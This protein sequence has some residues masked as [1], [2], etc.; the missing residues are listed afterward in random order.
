MSDWAVAL[1]AAIDADETALLATRRHL[2]AHPDL[3]GA[4][5]RTVEWLTRQLD[6]VAIPYR[7][8]LSGRGILCGPDVDSDLVAFR[9]DIDGL[10]IHDQKDVPY[11][12]TVPGAM[13]AC[14]HD[15]HSAMAL[16]AARAL[17]RCRE[18]LPWPTPWRAIFQPAE[19]TGEGA[20]E[21]VAA[22]AMERVRAIVALHVDPDLE[23]GRV[24][25]RTGV[26]TASCTDIEVTVHGTGGHAARPH[27]TTDPIAAAVEL[28]SQ[29]YRVVPRSVDA[30]EAVVVTFGSIHGGAS[31]NVIPDRVEL[32]GT[33]R[34]QSRATAG[35]VQGRIHAIG[36]SVSQATGATIDIRFERG[37][38]AVI[39]DPEVT[40][41][42]VE[43]V[44]ELVGP[45]QV[46]AIDLPSMGGED[47]GGYLTQG[48]GC[49]LRLG[50]AIA[51][52]PRV[53]LHS[54]HFDLD[55]RALAIGAKILAR[56]AVLL[57][58]PAST[59]GV[60]E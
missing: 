3:S 19:E 41:V 30:R 17:W 32:L 39:N 60:R 38:D 20:A 12:S 57:A 56:C 22:G 1:D 13:H 27:Q 53:P 51:G 49:L 7:V 6:N 15:A 40:R 31:F 23:V 37:V 25:Y 54:A 47:F 46:R 44:S 28:V 8:L 58:K 34:T 52:K 10:P 42:C 55:E 43:A 50:V 18:Q 26:M 11:R 2:H 48:P 21:M 33:L 45:D 29:I 59:G 4:E 16:G 24:A 35:R 14:G 9:A 36:Q 5:F